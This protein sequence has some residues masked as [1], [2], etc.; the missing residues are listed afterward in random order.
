MA[1][2]DGHY[3]DPQ[4]PPPNAMNVIADTL[5]L[6]PV[7]LIMIPVTG[8]IY[9]IGYPFSW[10]A[11]NQEETYQSLLGDTIDFTFRRPMGRG[12]PFD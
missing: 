7:G 2:A 11:G 10:A 1:V 12:E 3:R 9:V 4:P 5:I 6:R 8:L